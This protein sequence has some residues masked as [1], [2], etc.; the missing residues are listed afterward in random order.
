[1]F[2]EDINLSADGDI[3]PELV[4]NRSFEDSER[5]ESWEFRSSDGKGTASVV[6]ADASSEIVPL[7]ADN[8]RSLCIKAV[9]SFELEN[10]GYWGMN[11]I[12]GDR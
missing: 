9:G 2:F 1:V 4:K 12:Q 8:R 7:N 10:Q 5:P 3:Y 6:T 11:I